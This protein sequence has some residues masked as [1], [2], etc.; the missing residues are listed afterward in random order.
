M[1]RDDVLDVLERIHP[2]DLSKT[3]LVLRFGAGITLDSVVRKETDYLVVRGREAGTNDEG[4]VFFVP[5]ED[6]LFIKIDRVMKLTEVRRMFGER[7]TEEEDRDP[8]SSETAAPKPTAAE[9]SKPTTPVPAAASNDPASI[10]KQ[11]L[12][13]RIRAARTAT[14]GTGS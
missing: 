12:L 10:A 6:V 14:T 9:P 4:R 13:A 8:L 5:Y 1:L 3:V 7:V 2:G 11:N